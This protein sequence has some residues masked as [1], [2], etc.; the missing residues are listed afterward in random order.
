M[1]FLPRLTKVVSLSPPVKVLGVISYFSI[2]LKVLGV[3][4]KKNMKANEGVMCY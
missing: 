2:Y 4:G 3:K 1:I